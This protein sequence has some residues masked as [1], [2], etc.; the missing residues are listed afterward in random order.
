MT[1]LSIENE[2]DVTDEHLAFLCLGSDSNTL[3]GFFREH[4]NFSTQMYL[5]FMIVLCTQSASYCISSSQ[6][7][8]DDSLL[9][10]HVPISSEDELNNIW[11][12]ISEQRKVSDTQISTNSRR[13]TPLWE[14]PEVIVCDLL[15][16]VSIID[17]E[18]FISLSLDDDDKIWAFLLRILKMDK[19]NLKYMTH[20]VKANRKGI[21]AH[22]AVS[23]GI[24]I[25]LGICFERVKDSTLDCFQPIPDFLF[26]TMEQQICEMYM[27]TLTEDTC[28]QTLFLDT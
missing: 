11:K 15:R 17:C 7:Y 20:H 9:K 8:D 22:T 6:L 28:F 19:R 3:T 25:P 10:E 27:C 24:M 16:S 5:E 21:I 26:G 18:G 1:L 12:K 23:N 14:H 13:D 2:D 4:L